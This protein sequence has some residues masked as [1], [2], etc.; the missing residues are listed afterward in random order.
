MASPVME[1]GR[2]YD[3]LKPT[4][5]DVSS[6]TIAP[7]SST[8]PDRVSGASQTA[9]VLVSKI[10]RPQLTARMGPRPDSTLARV[11]I[12]APSVGTTGG[13]VAEL[14]TRPAGSINRDAGSRVARKVTANQME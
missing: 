8:S 6:I 10:C 4:S 3:R 1:E 14:A 12:S 9:S 11:S 5:G 2:V 13:I 7:K